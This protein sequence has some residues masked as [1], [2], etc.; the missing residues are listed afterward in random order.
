MDRLRVIG[1]DY[2]RKLKLKWSRAKNDTTTDTSHIFSN[3]I[4]WRGNCPWFLNRWFANSFRLSSIN[5]VFTLQKRIRDLNVWKGTTF[6]KYRLTIVIYKRKKRCS[7]P[8]RSVWCSGSVWVD[9]SPESAVRGK[10]E[11]FV[12]VIDT[13]FFFYSARDHVD[14]DGKRRV[15]V[16]SSRWRCAMNWLVLV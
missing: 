7:V 12:V 10:L 9:T 16:K 6:Q 15:T 5:A 11:E 4:T 8:R 3:T 2:G 1:R 13:I 14:D